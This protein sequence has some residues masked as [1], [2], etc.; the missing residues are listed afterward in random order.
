MVMFQ[1]DF[2]CGSG[3]L[4]ESLLEF[5][6]SLEKIVGVDLSRKSLAHAAKVKDMFNLSFDLVFS[7]CCSNFHK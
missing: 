6:T 3:S 1:V 7:S 2:G 5:P 4:L